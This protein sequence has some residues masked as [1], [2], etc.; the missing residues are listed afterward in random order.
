[1][2][3][4]VLT[5]LGIFNTLLNSAKALKDLNDAAVRNTA[6]VELQ[7]KILA[8]K[9]A[10]AALMDQVRA[11]EAKVAAFENWEAQKQRYQMQRF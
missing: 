11:L 2:V 3:G 1:M 10:Q 9:E 4:E 5:G 6:V 8:A 7:E